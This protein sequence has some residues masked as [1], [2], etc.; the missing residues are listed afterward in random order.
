VLREDRIAL[1]RDHAVSPSSERSGEDAGAGADLDHDVTRSDVD[2]PDELVRED[3]APQEVLAVRP[4]AVRPR[5]ARMRGHG[6]SP[7]RCP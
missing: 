4:G 6:P 2:L 3:L 7:R 1:D 5:R